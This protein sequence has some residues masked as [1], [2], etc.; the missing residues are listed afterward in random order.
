MPNS[1]EKYQVNTGPKKKNCKGKK[2][3]RE[4]ERAKENGNVAS[5]MPQPVK[6]LKFY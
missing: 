2:G 4:R 1:I 6:L 5:I 3:K